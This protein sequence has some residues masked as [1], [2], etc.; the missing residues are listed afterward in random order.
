MTPRRWLVAPTAA[1]VLALAAAPVAGAGLSRLVAAMD[2]KDGLALTGAAAVV[3]DGPGSRKVL[4]LDGS[5]TGRIDLAAKKIDPGAYDLLKMQVKADGRAALR[6]SLENYPKP[7]DLSHWY[8]LD[9]AR[10]R[11][12]WRT[13][14]IDLRRPEEIKA[15]GTYKGMAKTDPSARGLR[16]LGGARTLRASLQGPGR[17]LWLGPIRFARKAV[18]LDWDQSR[19]PHTWGKGKDLVFTYP[20]R[21][22]NRL[23]K[24]VTAEL[25][26]VPF[27]VTSA[28]ATLSARRVTLKPRQTQIIQATVRLPAAVAAKAEP[29]Y[30]ERFEARA[31]AAGIDDSTVTIL[32][33][34]DP[35]HLTVTVPIPETKLRF[36]LM[37]R[38]KDLPLAVCGL[39]EGWQ[40]GSRAVADAAGPK[41]LDAAM[42]GA[43]DTSWH[44]KTG[45]GFGFSGGATAWK[46]ASLR[47]RQG[48]TA[49]AFLYDFTGRKE[50]LEKG[51][52]LLVRAAEHFPPRQKDW[53]DA[54][55]APISHGVM[56]GNT[57]SL[58]WATGGMRPPYFAQRHGMFNDF[59]LL[60]AGMDPA[61]R[62]KILRGLLVPAAIQ[63]RNHYFGL[64]NQQDVVN[65]PVL[66]AGL[67]ARN[68]PLV[69]FAYSSEHGVKNQI[70][71]NFDDNG[72][73]G[74]GHY[75]AATVRPILYA[76]ELLHQVG[77][78]LYDQRLYTIVR[79][80]AAEALG[81][82]YRDE[83][84][85]F[86]ETERFTK[87]DKQ[88]QPQRTD[89]IHLA[90][91][92]TLLRWGGLEVG[93][94]WG[95]HIHRNA[96]D[97]CTLRIV[98]RGKGAPRGLS[99]LGGGNYTH[100]SL[101]QSILILDENVQHSLPAEVTSVDVTGPVQ[102]VQ[103]VSTQHYPGST[104]TRTFALIGGQSVL[105]I[106]R[107]TS[108][109]ARTV[110]WCLRSEGKDLSAPMKQIKG[111]F[112][113][114][115]G[116]RA[117]GIQFGAKL[118]GG[119]YRTGRTSQTWREGG[120][121]MTMLGGTETQVMTFRV[122]ASF[123]AAKRAKETGVPVLMARRTGVKQTDFVCFFS[124]K[125]RSVRRSR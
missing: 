65:Y 102:H 83:I 45:R 72:L 91:G 89:G 78:D 9:A 18:D 6:V 120:G 46:A 54:P 31:R 62:E 23:D 47:Y 68:W 106:D 13:I 112:T 7:G 88:G 109:R 32:R 39:R 58:G 114:K 1:L 27:Q 35:V 118:F 124:G 21:V 123:S 86:M 41:D 38:R 44:P 96:P 115:P 17:R 98:A 90:S 73:C 28:K 119:S 37:Q 75:Q 76:V 3:P 111:S 117:H 26:L 16:L 110:D 14:W 53:A 116:D 77:V 57:L 30:C 12:G 85:D 74:E 25:S 97:R 20:L 51:T 55:Y 122:Q 66:Y 11:F 59:D 81:L 84:A 22:T 5:F 36:P 15:A 24:A 48:L 100:S 121:R 103:A 125:T 50:Y 63:M 34:S 69:S 56:A 104:I 29:L 113:S 70:R 2:S 94:N 52:A 95:T 40:R 8:V 92:T 4:R 99:R 93:M 33:S 67:A 108:S 49:C 107:V 60:A 71:W 61:A 42:D 80:R 82:R 87:A 64:T 79:S 10:G 19:A 105:V 101:G 43:L